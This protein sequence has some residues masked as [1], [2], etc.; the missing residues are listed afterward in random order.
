MKEIN[1][2]NQME[3]MSKKRE[4][5]TENIIITDEEEIKFRSLSESYNNVHTIIIK[6]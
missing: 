2:N 5:E 1:K 6:Q 3:Q 4:R